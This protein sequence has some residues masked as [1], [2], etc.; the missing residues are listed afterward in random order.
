M[1]YVRAVLAEQDEDE[2]ARG[3]E[4]GMLRQGI[5]DPLQQHARSGGEGCGASEQESERG[6]RGREGGLEEGREPGPYMGGGSAA[7]RLFAALRPRLLA[8]PGP[9]RTSD[10]A[11]PLASL[12]QRP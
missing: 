9:M 5:R 7:P 10:R 11:A 1:W 2:S 12:G 8:A 3:A 4:E 6:E